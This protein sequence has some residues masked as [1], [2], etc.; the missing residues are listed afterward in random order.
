V[1]RVVKKDG[2]LLRIPDNWSESS[3]KNVT[4]F[5]PEGG[6]VFDA[7]KPTLT[8]GVMTGL[9]AIEKLTLAEAN[10]RLMKVFTSSNTYLT[11][12]QCESGQV[13]DQPAIHCT[14]S[15]LAPMTGSSESVNTYSALLPNGYL[16]YLVAIV[17]QH[18]YA[19]YGESFR[20]ILISIRF[21]S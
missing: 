3:S 15:G 8:H 12:G 20:R 1:L 19:N 4:T 16:F 17:P 18:E 5:A 11:L 9:H 6:Y 14:L 7:D 13:N 10:D 2:Y 21:H